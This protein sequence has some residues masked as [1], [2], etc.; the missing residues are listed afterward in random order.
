MDKTVVTNVFWIPDTSW[1]KPTDIK[2]SPRDYDE[3]K[4]RRK[5]I[6]WLPKRVRK[7]PKMQRIFGKRKQLKKK[8][9]AKPKRERPLKTKGDR[10]NRIVEQAYK[11]G[12]L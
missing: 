5:K 12:K 9:D 8:K 3:T 6:G 10:F 4:R 11:S 2:N 1:Y 7:H